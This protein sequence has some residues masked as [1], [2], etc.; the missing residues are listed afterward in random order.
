MSEGTSKT[1][2]SLLSSR[3]TR[4]AVLGAGLA[5]GSVAAA[6]AA[7][8]DP[9][10]IF[11]GGASGA[12]GADDAA[13]LKKESV[14]V[15]HLLRRAG[16]GATPEEHERYQSLGLQA[17]I[18]ELVNYT[19]VD[20]SE[21]ESLASQIPVDI[22]NRFNLPVWWL[23]RMANTKRPLQE[24]MTLFWHGH[25]T[26]QL[27]VVQDPVAMLRQNEFFRSHALATFPEIVRG[28]SADPAMMVYLDIAGST[29][30]APN[31]NYAR[32]L[33]ELFA[34]GIGNYTEQ[35]I[36]E[37]ARAF[38][39][40]VVQRTF[41][42]V[43]KPPSLGDPVF[44]SQNFDSG[45]KTVFG[46]TGNFRAEDIADLVVHQ[47]ASAR[48][49]VGKLFSYFV[50]QDPEEKTLAP[51]VE[52]YT[53]SGMSVRSTVESILRSE[54]FYSPKAYRSQIKSP[55]EYVVGAVKALGQQKVITQALGQARG[56]GVLTNMGQVLF[57]PPNVAG[58]PG[59]TSWLNSATIFA[60]LNFINQLTGG[61]PQPRGR[62]QPAPTLPTGL[63][64]AAQALAQ[65]LP[66]ALDDNVPE[67]ARQVLLDYA[68]GPDA[69][70]SA[71][72]LRGLTYL[73][74][75]SPQFHVA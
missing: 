50:Y 22:D 29:R 25:L 70:L 34:L 47:P 61:G 69:T 1:S 68:G 42:G 30:R 46:Q 3:A 55:V 75:A 71:E 40:W 14:R 62:A 20:D 31:E 43:G 48:F 59:G 45:M 53:K 35:D 13:A 33:M 28:I 16:F 58:W 66:V 18:D 26:S 12:R 32:E 6:Y 9:L 57:E 8:G 44:R 38:T 54:V 67:E 52:V 39:G 72:S 11:Q 49:I 73:V 41:N 17:T 5:A 27:S 24:K 51:F 4:R 56:G 74:L 63:G 2:G 23:L 7:L 15:S 64:T 21:A 65:F 37:A 60:R 19:L 36:R 10:D